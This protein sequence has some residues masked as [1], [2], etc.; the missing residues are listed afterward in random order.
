MNSREIR[1]SKIKSDLMILENLAKE[2]NLNSTKS[3]KFF[4][5]KSIDL[6]GFNWVSRELDL[7]ENEDIRIFPSVKYRKFLLKASQLFHEFTPYEVPEDATNLFFTVTILL[8]GRPH[9]F[10]IE[11]LRLFTIFELLWQ[12]DEYVKNDPEIIY[13]AADSNI[14]EIRTQKFFD[15]IREAIYILLLRPSVSVY[16]LSA[17]ATVISCCVEAICPYPVEDDYESLIPYERGFYP[18]TLSDEDKIKVN[19]IYILWVGNTEEFIIS[20]SNWKPSFVCPLVNKNTSLKS[21]SNFSRSFSPATDS[22][23][24]IEVYDSKDEESDNFI[25]DEISKRL[26]SSESILSSNTITATV[27]PSTDNNELLVTNNTVFPENMSDPIPNELSLNV[28]EPEEGL[29]L[30]GHSLDRIELRYT[31]QEL[32]DLL[33]SENSLKECIKKMYIGLKTNC[34]FFVKIDSDLTDRSKLTKAYE[35]ARSDA[36]FDGTSLWGHPQTKTYLLIVANGIVKQ[37]EIRTKS[38]LSLYRSFLRSGNSQK[39][40]S[41][42]WNSSVVSKKFYG[43]VFIA[44]AGPPKAANL[45]GNA[46]HTVVPYN[47]STHADIFKIREAVQKNPRNAFKSIILNNEKSTVRG[48]IQ[49]RDALFRERKERGLVVPRKYS[50]MFNIANEISEVI[51]KM[52]L[53]HGLI[54]TQLFNDGNACFFVAI[55]EIFPQISRYCSANSEE[56]CVLGVDRTFGLSSLWVTVTVFHQLGLKTAIRKS[57]P[58]FLGPVLISTDATQKTFEWF[59]DSIK[60]NLSESVNGIA[61]DESSLIFGSD[62]EK[63]IVKA[64]ESRWPDATRVLCDLHLSRNLKE[65]FRVMGIPEKEGNALNREIRNVLMKST[66]LEEFDKVNE[67]LCKQI[68]DNFPKMSQYFLKFTEILRNQLISGLH[69]GF[70]S[71]YYTN[72]PCESF[73]FLL[74]LNTGWKNKSILNLIEMIL[75]EMNFQLTLIHKALTNC[76]SDLYL[77][78]KY[79]IYSIDKGVWNSWTKE[80]QKEA[81]LRF[82]KGQTPLSSKLISSTD[83]SIIINRRNINAARKPGYKRRKNCPTTTTI[84]K[85]S[86]RTMTPIESIAVQSNI[87]I[88]TSQLPVLRVIDLRQFRQI[89]PHDQ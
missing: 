45:H 13:N 14:E 51:A 47:R 34:Y 17:I 68:I 8:T 42:L 44:Y 58:V 61:L 15:Y 19:T 49:V 64:L 29:A 30:G 77:D 40:I 36:L 5:S 24:E 39:F 83:H 85:R 32:F 66:T 69:V 16:S 35:L 53:L 81:T 87:P 21:Q 52:N 37:T 31:H 41:F 18:I 74:K 3:L 2:I 7:P 6:F 55:P 71:G 86:R 73:N 79:K 20:S 46:K 23:S 80:M 27:N 60:S 22:Q 11:Q 9:L 43:L 12:T 63:A 75:D 62:Q 38:N 48:R 54:A 70:G 56:S 76:S 72:N 88:D 82:L 10:V 25:S 65:K 67:D 4:I 84:A 89:S 59:F 78:E 26:S 1:I 57:H 50:G 33:T 28:F